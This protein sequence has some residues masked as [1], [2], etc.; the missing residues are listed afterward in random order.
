M[1]LL[2]GNEDLQLR[3]KALYYNGRTLMLLRGLL[4]SPEAL[5]DFALGTVC[6]LEWFELLLPTSGGGSGL[7]A[8]AKHLSAFRAILLARPRDKIPT[9]LSRAIVHTSVPF[10]F[11]YST[12]SPASTDP[13]HRSCPPPDSDHMHALFEDPRWL[14]PVPAIVD[15]LPDCLLRLRRS[16]LATYM[17]LPALIPIVA[18]LRQQLQQEATSLSA[19]PDESDFVEAA[20]RAEALLALEDREAEDALLHAVKIRKTVAEEDARVAPYSL[21]FKSEHWLLGAIN[22]W[23]T[24]MMVVQL[25]LS[26]DELW[27]A[28]GDDG[29]GRA[30]RANGDDNGDDAAETE[31]ANSTS[32]LIPERREQFLQDEARMAKNVVMSWQF[33][34]EA[35]LPGRMQMVPA[36]KVV[37]ATL[38]AGRMA[39]ARSAGTSGSVLTKWILKKIQRA[40]GGGAGG[41]GSD[42]S[43]SL[44]SSP[45][46]GYYSEASSSFPSSS[47]SSSATTEELLVGRRHTEDE[48]AYAFMLS[49]TGNVTC[50]RV[51]CD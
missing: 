32:W 6:L 42:S 12:S 20:V 49:R 31:T 45:S 10:H 22:Y 38:S 29:T 23:Q 48:F 8:L 40:R 30:G 11:N 1:L 28:R 25:V 16:A 9:A 21:D 15:T 37:L 19:G 39:T 4:S 18:T 13:A 34:K 41:H 7:A 33:V 50:A 36:L 3:Q 26:L 44:E 14:E 17:R 43:S 47:S 5:S 2:A 24:R 27:R 35:Y 51:D 46:T